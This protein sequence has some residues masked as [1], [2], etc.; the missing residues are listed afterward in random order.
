MIKT[1]RVF[2]VSRDARPVERKVME[3]F[4][5]ANPN[6][7]SSNF[8]VVP[9]DD[10]EEAVLVNFG[11]E[12]MESGDAVERLSRLGLRP[13]LPTELVDLSRSHPG[14]QLA[15]CLPVVALGDSWV[16][17]VGPF[18]RRRRVAYLDGSAVRRELDLRW[19]GLR[20]Y[21]RWWFLAFRRK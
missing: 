4:S 1:Q 19:W 2:R 13:G 17:W 9:P 7:T 6:I 12:Y 11:E 15:A 20:W 5:Y 18:G 14:G 3:G 16:G 21:G 8:R 10:P